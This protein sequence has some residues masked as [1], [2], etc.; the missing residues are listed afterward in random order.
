MLANTPVSGSTT[1]IAPRVKI[2]F[3][4]SFSGH[5][6]PTS[7][8]I[9]GPTFNFVTRL[10]HKNKKVHFE[11]IHKNKKAHFER[12]NSKELNLQTTFTATTT[13]VTH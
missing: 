10:F 13:N 9:Y 3:G 8:K 2:D 11:R 6:R 4:V 7:R 5:I 1:T 12:I